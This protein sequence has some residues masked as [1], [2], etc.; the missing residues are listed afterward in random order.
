V[1]S[2]TKVINDKSDGQQF[3]PTPAADTT[4]LF[5][6]CGLGHHNNAGNPL[7][8]ESLC[9]INRQPWCELQS[10]RASD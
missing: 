6:V 7:Q 10:Q 3:F 8:L 2:P 1:R 4:G 9:D 5:H